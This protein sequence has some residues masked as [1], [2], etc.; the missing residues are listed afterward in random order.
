[1]VKVPAVMSLRANKTAQT[2]RDILSRPSRMRAAC[3]R[4]T[5]GG[6]PEGYDDKR[7]TD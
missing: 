5:A 7:E 2:R 3:F 1:M 6:K 4:H